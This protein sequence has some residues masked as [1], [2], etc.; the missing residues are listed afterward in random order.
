MKIIDAYWEKRNIGLKTCEII[1]EEKDSIDDYMAANIE[2]NF[3]YSVAKIPSA[4]LNILHKLEDIGYK[5]IETQFNICVATTELDK[6][7]KKWI[8]IIDGTH[9]QRLQNSKDLEIILSNVSAGMF[10]TDRISLDE[11][12]GK[13]TSAER[14]N[15]WIKDLYKDRDTEI[16]YLTK[17]G[18]R[19]GFFVLRK[20]SKNCFTSVIAGVFNEYQGHGL[21]VAIIYYY[22]KLALERDA[23]YVFTSFSSNNMG[24]LNSFTKTVSFKTIRVFYVLRKL[25]DEKS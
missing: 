8:R 18:N 16:F 24:M 7:Y 11:K 23:K 19:A 5:F 21:S 14:Y 15:N 12:L 13:E 9:Y 4:N 20:D 25:I 3:R 2:K 17:Q 10:N 22:L 1:F 6:L